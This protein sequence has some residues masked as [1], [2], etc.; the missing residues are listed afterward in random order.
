MLPLC[1]FV[2]GFMSN[3]WTKYNTQPR[4]TFFWDKLSYT[5]LWL[6]LRSF[7]IDMRVVS[8]DL[9]MFPNMPN[10]IILQPITLRSALILLPFSFHSLGMKQKLL[11]GSSLT[12][13]FASE[14][15]IMHNWNSIS[16]HDAHD[17]DTADAGTHT[18][19]VSNFSSDTFI[20]SAENMLTWLIFTN[21][22][23]SIN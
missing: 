19:S 21:W 7:H 20:L 16:T 11:C 1:V 3:T 17:D 14:Y 9:W 8:S 22:L 13:N 15:E 10:P 6:K 12:C 2:N 18:D 5:R 23:N 4:C